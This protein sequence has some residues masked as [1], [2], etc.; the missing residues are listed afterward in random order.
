MVEWSQ[1]GYM[2]TDTQQADSTMTQLLVSATGVAQLA[3]RLRDQV[4]ARKVELP[5][6]LADWLLTLAADTAQ[7][8]DA[9][10]DAGLDPT[11]TMAGRCPVGCGTSR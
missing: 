1:T 10:Y 9:V 11:D 3:G 5:V 6:D 4:V 2:A 7:L 8:R